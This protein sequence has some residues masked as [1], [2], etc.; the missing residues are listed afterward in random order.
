[1][2]LNK[3]MW[4]FPGTF[5]AQRGN[6]LAKGPPQRLC[7]EYAP[8][9][10]AGIQTCL[11]MHRRTYCLPRR[12]K[13]EK[14]TSAA[15]E[16]HVYNKSAYF[17]FTY[18]P[19]GPSKTYAINPPSHNC[20]WFVCFLGSRKLYFGIVLQVVFFMPARNRLRLNIM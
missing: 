2:N 15:G 9:S 18:I 4:G 3:K 10:S 6:R 12:R 1:M 8:R 13:R 16:R 17:T 19:A 5:S 20:T 11:A 14:I 7:L